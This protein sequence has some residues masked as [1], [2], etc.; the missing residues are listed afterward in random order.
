MYYLGQILNYIWDIV[1]LEFLISAGYT[2]QY[3]IE[4]I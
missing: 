4:D 1:A 3:T 2:Y